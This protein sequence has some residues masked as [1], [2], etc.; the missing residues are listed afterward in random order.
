MK[1]NGNQ[2]IIFF[3]NSLFERKSNYET[4]Q[5]EYKITKYSTQKQ[6][7]EDKK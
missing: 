6:L 1:K 2:I 7:K 5:L 4:N 3:L